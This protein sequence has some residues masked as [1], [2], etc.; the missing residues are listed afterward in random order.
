MSYSNSEQVSRMY[1]DL[2]EIERSYPNDPFIKK[3]CELID[4]Q[5]ENLEE[6]ITYLDSIG[7]YIHD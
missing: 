1:K 6:R 7:E 5:L 3:N 4:F 2:A